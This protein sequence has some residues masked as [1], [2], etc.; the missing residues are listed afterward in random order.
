MAHDPLRSQRRALFVGVLVSLLIAGGAVMLGLLRPQPSIGDAH[1]VADETGTLHVR[2]DDTFH[3]ITNVA[4]ARLVLQ[5]PVEIQ[6]ST[7][8][9]LAEFPHGE[10]MGIAV[11]PGL[12]EAPHRS[13]LYCEPGAVVAAPETT[14]HRHVMLTTPSGTWMVLGKQRY[15]VDAAAA[16]AMGATEHVVSDDLVGLLERQP[17]VRMPQGKTGLPAPFDVAGR[18]LLAGD[19]AFM[20]APGGVAELRGPQRQLAEALSTHAPISVSLA[21]AVAQPSV[22]V[23]GGVP[24]DS[25]DWADVEMLCVGESGMEEPRGM[26]LPSAIG[27]TH[28]PGTPAYAGPHFVGPRGTSAVVTER[29]YALVSESGLRFEVGSEAELRALGFGDPAQAPWRVVSMLPAAGLLSESNARA[30]NA[31]IAT[32]KTT[33]TT[34]PGTM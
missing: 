32:T 7:S 9:Q 26:E 10:P 28:V 14:K 12:T 2:L 33:S 3:P 19:R 22:D 25:V 23:L 20:A 24:Q 13:F 4:S 34:A 6:Q 29:G 11:V 1:L 31:T 8:D 21:E 5:Q 18:V 30:T 15:L 17:D 16:R 27:D